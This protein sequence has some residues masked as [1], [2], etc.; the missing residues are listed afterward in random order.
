MLAAAGLAMAPKPFSLG[1]R[2]EHSQ[3]WLDH[4]QYGAYAGH[5]ALGA[6]DYQLVCHLPGGR[7]VYSFCA[8]PGGRVVA[9]ASEAGG[10]VTNGMSDYR[11]D[12]PRIN[13]A[14]LVGVS[15][16][17]YPAGPLGGVAFQ[18]T[19]ERLAFIAGG[20]S[21]QAPAQYAAD[22]LAGQASESI[23]PADATYRPGVRPADLAG[24]L[25][26]FVVAALRAAL[27][28]FAGQLPGFLS[29]DAVLTGVES[30]SSSPLRIWRG[31]DC[32]SGL[33]GLYPCGEGAGYAGGIMSAAADG[34]RCAQ[35]L[36]RSSALF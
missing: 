4:R 28:V 8:C 30:R 2:I 33:R 35:A 15:P 21:Y 9:A 10:L 26:D 3:A 29:L 12:G 14:L 24:C 17:D 6:A 22:F 1:V 36:I 27:P 25:P 7:S 19:Y 23:T 11:R 16:A 31:P 18:R 34:I 20:E 32:Q 13:S 5:P